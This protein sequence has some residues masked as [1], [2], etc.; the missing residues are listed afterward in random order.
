MYADSFFQKLGETL[1]Y[2][3][4]IGFIFIRLLGTLIEKLLIPL[5]YIYIIDEDKLNKT[6]ITVNNREI[7]LGAL[8]REIAFTALVVIGYVIFLKSTKQ[9]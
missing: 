6:N 8:L 1:N 9:I 5:V 7:Q 2:K 4:L 3:F